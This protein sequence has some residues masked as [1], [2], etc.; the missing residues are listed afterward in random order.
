[1]VRRRS[2][3]GP[4]RQR[5]L[6]AS[7]KFLAVIGL[8]AASTAAF[9]VN[10]QWASPVS[11]AWSAASNWT[12]P[13]VPTSTA[14]SVYVPLDAT[15]YT[16]TLD[17]N[18]VVRGL[19]LAN[20]ATTLTLDGHMLGATSGVENHG[21]IA[22]PSGLTSVLAGNLTNRTTAAVRAHGGSVLRVN[23]TQWQNDGTVVVNLGEPAEARLR[24][25]NYLTL[26]G[27]GRVVLQDSTLAILDSPAGFILTNAAG[28]AITGA[29][30][31]VAPLVNHGLVDADRA[32][33]DLV[34]LGTGKTNDGV[35]S[36]SAGGR[37]R[38]S[39]IGV[40]NAG[41]QVL[42]DDGV[43]RLDAMW[44]N[45]GALASAGDGRIV[46]TGA[47]SLA[48]VSLAGE[49]VVTAGSTTSLGGAT[50]VNTGT[51]LVFTGGGATATLRTAGYVTASGGGTIVLGAEALAILDSPAGYVFT[52]GADH[53]ITGAGVITAPLVNHGLVSADLA[54][55]ELVLSG[56]N[57]TNDGTLQATAGG[58][59]RLASFNLTNT[60]GT[61][62]ADD[63][64]VRLESM[65]LFGGA[66]D[67]R[68][69]GS[70][71][72]AGAVTLA[73][74]SHA[75][76]L[77]VTGGS[78]AS[79]A[80]NSFVNEGTVQVG[81]G[82]AGTAILRA[83]GYVAIAGA[84][85]I[86]LAD[87]AVATLDSPAGYTLTIGG[88]QTIHGAGTITALLVNH[89]LVSA[90]MAGQDLVLGG[91]NKTND[92]TLE[93]TDGGRLRIG[94]LYLTNTGGT[95]QA[96]G[97]PVR[98][99]SA[100]VIAGTLATSDG[101]M[102]T[103]AG[104][105]T[106]S[107]VHTTGD[108]A[109]EGG[110]VLQL[111]GNTIA[112]DGHLLVHTGGS[113]ATTLRVAGYVTLTGTGEVELNDPA[114][115]SLTSPAGYTLT[116]GAG[117]AIRGA[118][119]VLVALLNDGEVRADHGGE[120]LVLGGTGKTNRGTFAASDGG[121]L[122][123]SVVPTN[124]TAVDRRL[125]DGAWLAETGGVIQ[126]TGCPV[127][128]I[129]ADVVLDG[130]GSSL[131]RDGAGTSALAGLV[132]VASGATFAVRNDRAFTTAPGFVNA[133]RLV[134]G[135]GSVVTVPGASFTQTPG[136]TLGVE[137]AS[138]APG[139]GGRLAVAGHADL[140]GT[141]A[142]DAIG[143]FVPAKGDTYL[144]MTF[145]SR[146]G[147]FTNAFPLVVA[148]MDLE[149][150]WRP[151]SLV[152]QVTGGVPVV[153][154]PTSALPTRLSFAARR[155]PDGPALLVLS[156]PAASTVDVVVFDL[157]GRRV[158]SLVHQPEPAGVH[159]YRWNGAGDGGGRVASGVYLARAQVT[160]A[161]RPATL[162][163]RV[164]VVR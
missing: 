70:I 77:T 96:R 2:Y 63:A 137:L 47:V 11:G 128:T 4:E 149:P 40:T 81:D 113:S 136:G 119:T 37:L 38:I 73:D 146:S 106:V 89:G 134:V 135:R 3:R 114:L 56:T 20:P 99:D 90:D 138:A 111:A 80:G 26:S 1:M 43:V 122:V 66:L 126:L 39:G 159:E 88:D 28:H 36:A 86:V 9:A 41:G 8:V 46:T 65:G 48:D 18:A 31:I 131:D 32:G 44:L 102:I 105:A 125:T 59:L 57:K 25:E 75:G 103:A 72:T 147:E 156:L 79:L 22:A 127:D 92:G 15:A 124:Y 7:T 97:G 54:G 84:G 117:H 140:A 35:L 115:A 150:V 144:L 143:D 52:N 154:D 109:V 29:G 24:I 110:S 16:I 42:A 5:G 21:I 12:P 130:A 94:A 78:V 74:V 107:D 13:G 67:A 160:A 49:L 33:E 10:Y 158:A 68:G 95:V 82:S 69:G 45:G 64:P 162:V 129:A 93:G 14:D 51:V 141:L 55:R 19:L 161:G 112:N 27:T 139:E 132:R 155:T 121:R 133:G 152:L 83:A 50:F 164:V 87:A 60:G 91:T 157:A 104:T 120:A 17:L 98:L 62:L 61:V 145:A 100:W 163:A 85:D 116:N 23:G 142:V 58:R 101:A 151:Q 53:A 118:G 76:L 108:L 148:G 153:D 123:L 30:Q 6:V 34:L 71:E